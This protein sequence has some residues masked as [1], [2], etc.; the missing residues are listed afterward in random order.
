MVEFELNVP[1]GKW[2]SKVEQLESGEGA[3]ATDL[4]CEGHIVRPWRPAGGHVEAK[5]VGLYRASSEAQL[6]GLLGALP[7]KRLDA[8]HRHTV[9]A[10]VNAVS[11]TRKVAIITGASQ[12]IGAGLVAGYRRAGYAVVRVAL[13]IAVLI[14]M[15]L[16]HIGVTQA[17]RGT[18]AGQP[19][20][21]LDRGERVV[22]SEVAAYLDVGTERV[23]VT[24]TA[25][26]ATTSP[27]EG[28]QS[29]GP[30]LGERSSDA[31]SFDGAT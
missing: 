13:S 3:A 29:A 24:C 1:E 7:I 12:G 2:E 30:H 25:S 31:A 27:I 26:P 22:F 16:G 21:L 20:G 19:A 23:H 28:P 10:A 4:A 8:D 14:M 18:V 5:F 11:H 9:R 17:V 6:E 15:W